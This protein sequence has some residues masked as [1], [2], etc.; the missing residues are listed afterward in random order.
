MEPRSS[1]LEAGTCRLDERARELGHL[2]LSG[3]VSAH[4]AACQLLS[5]AVDGGVVRQMC[6]RHHRGLSYAWDIDDI[7]GAVT[8]M[9]VSYSLASDRREG[10]LD[11]TRFADGQ[12]SASGWIG[13]VIGSMRSTRI[14]REMHADSGAV[15][16]PSALE[17]ASTPSAEDHVLAAGTPDIEE[18]T[19]GLPATSGTIRLVHASALHELLG[20]PPL[21]AWALTPPQAR[22]VLQA[23]DEDPTMLGRILA[24]GGGDIDASIAALVTDLWA[25]WSQDDIAS[26]Q[27]KSTP[28][29]D[30]PRV[31]CEAALRPLPRPRSRGGD[32]DRIRA[33][34]RKAAPTAAVPAV[35]TVL[36]AFL[37]AK[38]EPYTDFDR[39]RRPLS[40]KEAS[41][42]SASASALP[43]L[44]EEAA[45]QLEIGPLDVLSG[46]IGLFVQ[47]LPIVDVRYFAPTTWRFRS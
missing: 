1:T 29:R 12:T 23:L 21:R 11:V 42:R 25:G 19:K 3:R 2:V 35:T 5:E 47:P 13:K 20:L 26:M 34:A 36:D 41:R 38:V 32:L 40:A 22:R 9:L 16:D 27:A 14:L 31:V 15:L 39:L 43:A 37:D 28:V 4:D 8:A 46:L 6:A 24:G 7:I 33:R 45:R 17:Q 30:I 44:L 10:H 18:H